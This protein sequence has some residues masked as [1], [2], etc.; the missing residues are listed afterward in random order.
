VRIES[1]EISGFKSFGERTTLAFDGGVSAIVGPNGCGKSNVVDAVRWVMGEQNPRNLRGRKM[2]DIIFGG[3]DKIPASGMAEVVMTLDNSDGKAPPSYSEFSQI[4][5]ARRLYRSG[6]SEYLINKVVVRLRDVMDFFLDTGLSTRGYTIVEQG[7]IAGIV[8]N[9]PEERRAIFEEAA[10]IGKYRARRKEAES[11]LKS[12]EQ[13]LLRVNDI[14]AELKR[15]IGSL[16]RQAK[17]AT[18][19]KKL[20]AELRELEL[21]TAAAQHAAGEQERVRLDGQLL[22]LRDR[23][24]ALDASVAR[25]ESLLESER[26]AHLDRERE[27]QA[28]AERLF[29]L[30]SQI[31]TA[32]SRLQSE[33]RESE[34]LLRGAN[35]REAECTEREEQ[36]ATA[37]IELEAAGTELAS[38]E[39]E[40]TQRRARFAELEARLRS[41]QAEVANTEEERE[42]ARRS[43]LALSQEATK[44][45]VRGEAL[46]ERGAKLELQLHASEQS[47]EASALEERGVERDAETLQGQVAVGRDEQGALIQELEELERRRE[48]AQ[49]VLEARR[50][51]A[52]QARAQLQQANARGE[53]LVEEEKRASA[54]SEELLAQLPESERAAVRGLLAGEL[55][56]DEGLETA[57]E[58]VLA[59]RALVFLVDDTKKALGLL[60]ALGRADA[61]RVSV[62][63]LASEG[64]PGVSEPLPIGRRLLDGVRA[65]A[66]LVAAVERLLGDVVVVESLEEVFDRF[67]HGELPAVFVTPRG[68]IVD[69]RGALTGGSAAPRG[70]LSRAGEIRRLQTRSEALSASASELERQ[71]E[72]VELR[73]ASYRTQADEL[74]ARRHRS[75]LAVASLQ[76][77]LERARERGTTLRHQAEEQRHSQASLREELARTRDE[78]G[79]ALERGREVALELDAAQQN[80]DRLS[81][82][83]ELSAR[84]LEGVEQQRVEARVQLTAGE[85]RR[86]QLRETWNRLSRQQTETE[87]W[88]VRRR[89]EIAQARAQAAALQ[90]SSAELTASLEELLRDEESERGQQDVLRRALAELSAQIQA[91]EEEQRSA[92]REREAA[93]RELAELEL[94]A[95]EVRLRQTQ[96][97]D[98]IRERYGIEIANHVP[99]PGGVELEPEAREAEL[100]RIR[101]SL[102]SLG[103][104]HLGAIEEYEEVSERH[105]FLDEQKQDLE[106]SIERLRTAIGRINRTSRQRFREAFDAIDAQF[107][108]LFPKMFKGGRA[109]LTLTETEDV[110]DAGIEIHAQPPGK[111]LQTVILLSGGEKALTA[112][113]LLMAVFSVR[114]APF[115]LLDEVDAALDDANVGRFD[116]LLHEM[117]RS[118]QFLVITHNKSSIES[119][120]R[121]FG[122]TMQTPGL[123]KLVRVDLVR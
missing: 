112:L 7:A 15:Q 39:E 8:S 121:L 104:V 19:Y 33:R 28:Q 65:P 72:Q 120:D 115:F 87:Q 42:E 102:E 4:E 75:E 116:A 92:T 30:R 11:K 41:G 78:R 123:S 79:A 21:V 20:A 83:L 29:A 100:R 2:E 40:L 1:L 110:L 73:I 67:G 26:R 77:D 61:G 45:R 43:V 69:R 38:L 106:L 48:Q 71:S 53:A 108:Q 70:T 86:G 97:A 35:E 81:E 46:E 96:V 90:A 105:R 25:A 12:T 63:S 111:K 9:K 22:E 64:A 47:L 66:H 74:R 31:Q 50:S 114:P 99:E 54:R 51:A 107:Q 59:Q 94:A 37:R 68:E 80:S 101:E 62:L 6:E 57:L 56:V 84:E 91:L 16:D 44:L 122:V 103:P 119:A 117:S 60:H 93:R 27:A 58:G 76:K 10:G 18:R 36:L 113:A 23:S 3:T 118:A 34:G 14:I 5:I 88:L 55:S 24:T 89:E 13:N 98:R 32:E 109:H 17:R 85:G 49:R 82:L 52:A 95:Q